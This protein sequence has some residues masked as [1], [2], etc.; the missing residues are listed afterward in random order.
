MNVQDTSIPHVSVHALVVAAACYRANLTAW[1]YSP[2][3]MVAVVRDVDVS[4]RI[5]GNVTQSPREL[6]ARTI[7]VRETLPA[8]SHYLF[9][10]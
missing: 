1:R 8:S 6:S 2:Y 4:A 7:T 5:R 10:A 9:P 3:P